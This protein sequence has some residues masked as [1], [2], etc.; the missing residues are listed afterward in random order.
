MSVIVAQRCLNHF[1]REAA[2]RCPECAGFFCRECI[3]EHDERIICSAC[4]ARLTIRPEKEK[5]GFGRLVIPVY[6][7]V[8]IVS[9]WLFFYFIGRLLVSTPSSFHEGTV[10][11]QDMLLPDEE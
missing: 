4:L 2:A 5:R 1:N 8:G 3:T 10:W 6:L 11:K 7:A 9:A